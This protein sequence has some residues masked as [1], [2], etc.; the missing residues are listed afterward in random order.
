MS[1]VSAGKA[2]I[3]RSGWNNWG[4]ISRLRSLLWAGFLSAPLHDLSTRFSQASSYHG[5]LRIVRLPIRG[6]LPLESKHRSCQ[7]FSK[8]RH[9]AALWLLHSAGQSA[10][11][12]QTQFKGSGNKPCLSVG[13]TQLV[14]SLIYPT[15]LPSC[16]S[17][18]ILL[19]PSLPLCFPQT[20][21]GC[22]NHYANYRTTEM[23]YVVVLTSIS[24]QSKSGVFNLLASLGHV[25]R[26]IVWAM[27]KIH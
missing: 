9:G 5:S 16:L 20:C 17:F 13:T 19:H 14:A 25:G 12:G 24:L 26:R 2:Q 3:A 27:H 23:K 11:Q 6:W 18:F 21:I 22:F 4:R 8:F 15:S 10:S 7:T 1:G